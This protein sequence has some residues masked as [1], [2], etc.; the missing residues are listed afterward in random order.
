MRAGG[1]PGVCYIPIHIMEDLN[2]SEGGNVRLELIKPKKGSY[3]KLQPHSMDFVNMKHR[4]PK[5]FLEN[6]LSQNYP[7]LTQGHTI[8]LYCIVNKRSYYLDVVKTESCEEIQ[9]INVNLNVDFDPPID[10]L[11]NKKREE[12][13]KRRE[14]ETLKREKDERV[15]RMA[16]E[17]EKQKKQDEQY[18]KFPGEGRRLGSK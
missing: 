5:E 7:I 15:R 16:A 13:K 8:A 10:F 2:L 4:D 9:I 12:E 3:L 14:E 1:L 6:V 11:R 18:N 17:W